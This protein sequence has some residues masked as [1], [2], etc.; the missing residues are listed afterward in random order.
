MAMRPSA[1]THTYGATPIR[2]LQACLTLPPD[3]SSIGRLDGDTAISHHTYN[4]A[5]VAAGAVLKGVD[6]VMEGKAANVFCAVSG[7]AEVASKAQGP[8]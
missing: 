5:L 4:A 7:R 3:P 8:K 1:A 6:A 2:T